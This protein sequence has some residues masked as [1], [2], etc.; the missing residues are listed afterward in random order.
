MVGIV[1]SGA[2][3]NV[4]LFRSWCQCAMAI[5]SAWEEVKSTVG[6]PDYRQWRYNCGGNRGW[7]WPTSRRSNVP[8]SSIRC[9][10][11]LLSSSACCRLK[12][13]M[14]IPTPRRGAVDPDDSL[15]NI[16][17]N[18][19]GRTRGGECDIDGKRFGDR[20]DIRSRKCARRHDLIRTRSLIRWRI[21][22]APLRSGLVPDA[23]RFRS[24]NVGVSTGKLI[25]ATPCPR[26]RGRPRVAAYDVC[27]AARPVSST[28]CLSSSSSGAGMADVSG[29]R[30]FCPGVRCW[31]WLPVESA[32]RATGGLLRG[33]GPSSFGCE[34]FV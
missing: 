16:E 5:P 28:S 13:S 1:T 8:T 22:C 2:E 10:W 21:C 11:R 30:C 3:Y 9:A 29:R 15:V 12:R 19:L 17:G 24:G 31:L 26:G 33:L 25:H 4:F 18:K 14:T 32:I 34:G 6:L 23:G 27:T 7:S 20:R